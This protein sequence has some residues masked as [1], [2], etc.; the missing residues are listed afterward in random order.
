MDSYC[1]KLHTASHFWPVSIICNCRHIKA[2]STQSV[3]MFV[4]YLCTEFYVPTSNTSLFI[5][6]NTAL[7]NGS[8]WLTCFLFSEIITLTKVLYFESQ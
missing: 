6:T 4:V 8:V 1:V 3:M 5:T 7:N 2:I